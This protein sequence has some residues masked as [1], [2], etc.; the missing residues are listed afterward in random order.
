MSRLGLERSRSARQREHPGY[1]L[2]LASMLSDMTDTPTDL[3]FGPVPSRRLGRSLGINNIPPKSCSYSCIYCQVG[4]TARQEIEPR[5]FYPPEMVAAAVSNRVDAAQAAGE[6]IDYLTFVPD[7]EPT[8]DI[9]LGE[10]IDRL[11][12]LG[13]RVA[14]ISNA[15]LVWREDVRRALNKADWVS[16]KLDSTHENIWRQTNKPHPA[17]QLEAILQGM[18]RFARDYSGTLVTE[19]M[20]VDGVND[21][22]ESVAGV[23]QFLSELKP[24]TAYLAAPTRPP[25]QR[26]VRAPAEDRV[27]QAYEILG[28]QLGDLQLLTGDEGNAF[29]VTGDARRDL[30]AI[31]AV[32][33]MRR[34]AVEH[35][36]ARSGQNW[37]LIKQMIEEGELVE[38]NFAGQEFYVRRLR[39]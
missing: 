29:A 9:N 36:I 28:A 5:V 3:A 31:T 8:L 18:Q 4:P 30:L 23:A 16:L 39:R 2:N 24:Q 12:P 6:Q 35:F 34:N 27:V 14:V 21:G 1:T 19:T 32:H 25:A 17:L 10:A 26:G 11:R 33:P 22:A 15:S 7:G 13:I 38:V 20:L 37:A